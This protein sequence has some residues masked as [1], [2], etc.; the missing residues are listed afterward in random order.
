V[1][2]DILSRAGPLPAAHA[3]NGKAIE[4]GRIYVAPPDHP[5][6]VERGYVRLTRGPK[7]NRFRPA[8]DY[9]LPLADIAPALVRLVAEPA[10]AEE[11]YPVSEGLAIETR[12]A[13]IA[14]ALEAEVMK[15]G[16]LSP[17]TCP[18]CHRVLIQLQAGSLLRF[19]CHTGHAFSVDSL[20]AEVTESIE[21]TLWNTL[22]GLNEKM[23]LLQ[24][25]ARHMRQE[26]QEEG[27]ASME[28]KAREIAGRLGIIRQAAA[29]PAGLDD[30]TPRPRSSRRHRP[31]ER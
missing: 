23:L 21:R 15:L 18:E 9:C 3:E 31:G 1:L 24:H 14:N 12:L 26:G 22:R 11:A 5:L 16:P 29:D 13:W 20:L 2:P 17:Y 28:D 25:L 19:R 4:L 30:K 6:L 27:A 7:E 10:P 8:V